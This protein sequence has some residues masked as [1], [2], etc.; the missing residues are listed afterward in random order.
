MPLFKT[1][2]RRIRFWIHLTG[3]YVRKYRLWFIAVFLV[4]TILAYGTVKLWS[5]VARNNLVTIGYVGT[6]TLENLETQVLALA[7]QSLITIDESGHPQ[8]S[9]ASH[10]TVSEDGKTYLVFLKDNLIWHDDTAV[11]AKDITIAI[12][13][14]S[15]KALNNKVIEFKLPNP[16][17]SFTT[18]LD[19]PIFKSKSFY[20]TGEFRIVDIDKTADVVKT[21]SLA[22]K[23]KDLPQVD[24][25]FYPRED[26]L[27][28]AIKIGDVKYAAVAN[29]QIFEKWTNLEVVKNVANDEIVTIFYNTKD[30]LLSSKELRQALTYAI[31][32]SN[33]DGVSAVS[34][35]SPSN[36]AY[37]EN[38][39]R[40]EYNSGR[41]K[42]LL[43]KSATKNPAITLTVSTEL[44][45][46]GQSIKGDWEDLGVSVDLQES[47]T[48][49]QTFQAYLAT[50][51]IP[52]DPDQYGL[53][54]STQK[55]TNLTKLSDVKIDKLLED[56][57]ITQDEGQRKELYL[58]FQKF[59]VEEAP[60]A[61]LYHPYKYQV[62]YKNIKHLVSKLPK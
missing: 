53:W 16:I 10:W 45:N 34:P 15:V 36:W 50:N 18:A 2:T 30:P 20:G 21:I 27:L 56:A 32:R 19:R 61:F 38:T 13:G 43:T 31:N 41:A 44:T 26:Q 49:P 7:T 37:N 62:T 25:K 42:E 6:Y 12:E 54:H 46:V 35:I 59:L 39:K 17:S 29:A 40:Y 33:F 51:K 22:P 8:P 28:N 1:K 48:V 24:V 9:L 55:S 11:D 47:Q 52:A 58:E 23:S 60:A 3:A 4:G 14:V 5:K 57:R